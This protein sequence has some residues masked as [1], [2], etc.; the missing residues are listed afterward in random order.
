MKHNVPDKIKPYVDRATLLEKAEKYERAEKE[1]REALEIS[2]KNPVLHN[3]LGCCLGNLERYE[4]A[5][6]EF[7]LA[8]AHSMRAIDELVPDSY[9]EEPAANLQAI[10]ALMKKGTGGIFSQ[11]FN[12]PYRSK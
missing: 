9:P 11:I 1:Y 10:N 12:R 5:A 6:E 2:P 4:E 8:I 7:S 3:N